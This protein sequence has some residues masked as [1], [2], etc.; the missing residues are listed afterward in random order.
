MRHILIT[1]ST[2]SLLLMAGAASA[3]SPAAGTSPSHQTVDGAGDGAKPGAAKPR[4][5]QVDP[6]RTDSTRPMPDPTKSAPPNPCDPAQ[7]KAGHR[8]ANQNNA[9]G[10]CSN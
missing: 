10:G 2:I 7:A 5:G 4:P 6:A 3:Q 8:H 1:A 9:S